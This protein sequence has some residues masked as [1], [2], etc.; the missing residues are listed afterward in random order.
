M[1]KTTGKLPMFVALAAFFLVPAFSSAVFAALEKSSK[2]ECALCH[3]MWL[4]VF[5]TNKETLIK[6]QPGNVLMKDT[7]GIVSSEEICYS[8]H[9]GYVADARYTVWKYNNHPVF[10]KP[11][12]DVKIP[13]ALTLSNKDELYCG[14]CHSPHSGR[15]AAPGA[16]PEETIPGPLSFLRL[17]NVDSSLCEACHVNEA[18]FKQ[19]NG[20]PVHT[21]KLKIPEMLFARGSVK[22]EKKDSVICET[23]H[24]VHGAK[25]RHI[26]VMDNSQSALCTACHKERII[27]GTLHDARVTMREETNLL[28]QSVSESG[29]CGACHVS[30]KSAGYKL[31]AR[32]S[33]PGNPASWICLSCHSGAPENLNVE[34][35]KIKGIGRY[36]HRLDIN[37]VP[38]GQGKGSPAPVGITLPVF[39][40]GGIQQPEGTMQCFTCHAVHQWDP[41]NP[42]NRGG[43]NITGDASN[44]FLRMSSSGSS[45]L[46]VECHKDKRQVLSFDHNLILT[47]PEARNIRGDTAA[48]SGSCGACHI[49]HNAADKQLWARAVLRG[50]GVAPQYCTGCHA[51]NGPAKKKLVGNHD[52]PVNVVSKGRD[53][54]PA[55]RIMELLPLYNEEGDT[56]GGDRIMCRTCHDP[57]IWSAG[58]KRTYPVGASGNTKSRA[59]KN[60][61]GDARNSFLRLVAS[62]SPDLCVVCHEDTALLVGTDHD[63]FIAAPTA[64]N[65]LGETVAE[66]GQCGVCHAVHNS[67]QERLLWAQAYGPVE[68][69]QHPMNSLCTCCHSKGGA[70]EDK[71]PPVATHP[72]GKLINNIFT[73]NNQTTGYIKI[74]DDHWKEVHVGDLSCSSCHS[75]YRWD[76]RTRTPGPG[77]KVEGNADTSFLLTSSDNTVCVDCHGESSIWRYIYFHSL[78]KRAMLKGVRP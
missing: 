7:Q 57:H 11:S 31:W 35:N 72:K 58:D 51:E 3:V 20:H 17:P 9:D 40:P 46:C 28:G 8:C 44:S 65:R 33:Q 6:W 41:K 50:N 45:A 18:H 73:F 70:A 63:L 43:K 15:E 34:P 23:C 25:G 60:V 75:F 27:A 42:D 32:K 61:E 71:I 10:K 62:P 30:H 2:K 5:R 48:V 19:S 14:T 67:G 59:L 52:H 53:I 49:P 12:K 4:D 56:R 54:P 68:E 36:S 74:F 1:T 47:A 22:A 76:H 21:D 13:S 66:A 26:T 24:A 64:K 29:P 77:R 69:N 37:A 38:K 55:G 78:Q 39:S 16:S